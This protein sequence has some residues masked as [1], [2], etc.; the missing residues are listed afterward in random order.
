MTDIITKYKKHKKIT[1]IFIISASLI[2][3]L[4][5]NFIIF[6]W[7][8][9]GNSLKTSIIDSK[10]S[11]KSDIYMIANSKESEKSDIYMIS[12][13]GS[14]TLKTNKNLNLVKN[15]TLSIIYNKDNISLWESIVNKNMKISSLSWE[16]WISTI[17][18]DFEKATNIS[19]WD[20][21]FTM[22][23]SK[24]ANTSEQINLINANF[25]DETWET[26]LFTS[27]WI[28]F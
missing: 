20:D 28:T 13:S 11:E 1:N 21:I 27:S 17:I 18:I 25:T 3:A 23:L 8:N 6:D 15:I 2:L 22:K 24:K 14:I 26:Y 16:A 19:A 5:I 9:L 10:E 12:N 7:N 4:S